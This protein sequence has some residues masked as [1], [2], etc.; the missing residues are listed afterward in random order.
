MT[1]D[2][3]PKQKRKVHPNSLANL[4]PFQPG[5]SGN[6]DG[7]RGAMITPAIRRFA[8]MKVADFYRLPIYDLTMAEALAAGILT[9]SLQNEG[10]R[11]RSE[12]LDRLD[13][14]VA[15]DAPMAAVVM[16]RE[17]LGVNM[18]ELG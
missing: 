2:A 1:A 14:P 12:L 6:P 4:R 8:N 11:E 16:V 13:G 10:G 7:H 9:L 18:Q 17:V 15:K 5:V 3:T